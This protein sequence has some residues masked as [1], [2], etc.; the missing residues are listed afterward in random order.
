MSISKDSSTSAAQI[1]VEYDGVDDDG[2]INGDKS[3]EK[4]SKGQKVLKVEKPQRPEKFAK[5]IGLDE[6]SFLTSDTRLSFTKMS[7]STTMENY[8][9]SLKFLRI[10]SR[11]PIRITFDGSGMRQA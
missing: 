4:S 5:T 6:P 3:I 9:P 2:S 1:V 8:W 7:S 10:G 11:K